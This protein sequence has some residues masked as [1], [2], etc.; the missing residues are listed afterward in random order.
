MTSM[1]TEKVFAGSPKGPPGESVLVGTGEIERDKILLRTAEIQE[2]QLQQILRMESISKNEL[3]V[4]KPIF[5]GKEEEWNSFESDWVDWLKARQIDVENDFSLVQ[6]FKSVLPSKL[7]MVLQL[8]QA[9]LKKVGVE[10][11]YPQ[12][13]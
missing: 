4:R 2:R 12:A 1:S 8:A 5:S 11:T 13:F 3:E 10:L 9:E 7:K 6:S